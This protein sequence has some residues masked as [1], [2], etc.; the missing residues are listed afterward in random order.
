MPIA[1]VGVKLFLIV[2]HGAVRLYV[3]SLIWSENLCSSSLLYL[4]CSVEHAYCY[5]FSEALCSCYT[6]SEAL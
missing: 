3:H 2:S 6:W 4:V 5:T 1:I